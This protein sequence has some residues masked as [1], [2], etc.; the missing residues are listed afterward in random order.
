MVT[1]PEIK[2]IIKAIHAFQ[3]QV[4]KMQRTATNPF[5]KK[6]YTPISEVLEVIREPLQAA[7]LS[8]VQF[9]TGEHGLTTRLMHNTGQWMEDTITIQAVPEFY[10]EKDRSGTVTFRSEQPHYTPQGQ[11]S[12]IT[13]ARRYSLVAILGLSDSDD[14]GNQASTPKPRGE[15]PVTSQA[16]PETD[17]PDD[18]LMPTTTLNTPISTKQQIA[19]ILVVRGIAK[20]KQKEHLSFAFPLEFKTQDWDGI[21]KKLSQ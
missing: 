3:G 1:S 13:Y 16:M 12:A 18:F 17:M 10:K 5:F 9:P 6:T 4:G 7:G 14:D 15:A 21:L 20:D 19:N 8:F 11:G 2:E